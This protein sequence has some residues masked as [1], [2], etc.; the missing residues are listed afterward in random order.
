MTSRRGSR[1][2]VLEWVESPGFL[3]ELND[4]LKPTGAVVSASDMRMPTGSA[5][6]REARL[7]VVG[8]DFLP[9][10]SRRDEVGGW[11]LATPGRG[12]TPN[13]DIASA[14]TVRGQRGLVLVEAKAHELELKKEGKAA[15]ARRGRQ[16]ELGPSDDSKANHDRI[17]L[18]IAQACDALRL[19]D[20]RVQLSSERHY[21]LANRV[22]FAW[23]LASLG[24][25]V[26]LVYL[27][28]LGDTGIADVGP[29]FMSKEAWEQALRSH[30]TDVFP[31][32]L[33]ERPIECG[34][35]P[36][37]FLA[38]SRNVREPSPPRAAF[39]GDWR[40]GG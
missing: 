15:P 25:P 37:W 33:W 22:A 20:P 8:R 21:Q 11:W 14:C 12:N 35:A 26:V 34:G 6:P 32:E 39:T 2:H 24:V 40:D 38:R 30:T 16:R 31:A 19:I 28:F 1:K 36:F 17:R 3:T 13:W 27:G 23:R 5:K 29:P 18:A 4:F 9:S 7:N 10:F